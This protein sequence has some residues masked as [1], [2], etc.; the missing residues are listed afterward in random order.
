MAEHQA[1]LTTPLGGTALPA[2][3]RTHRQELARRLDE[4]LLGGNRVDLL[5]DGPDTF[6]A[7]FR[8]I[9]GARDHINIESYIVEADGPGQALAERLIA[10]SRAGVRVNLLFD[11]VGSFGT[12]SGYFAR[13]REAGVAL[14]EYNP[15]PRWRLW[16]GQALHLRDHRKL[17]VVDGRIGFL[18]GV[19]I[20]SVYASGSSP[21][22]LRGN[23]AAE[24]APGWRDL[25]LRVEGPV[26]HSLQRLFMRHWRQ[27]AEL[28]LPMAHYLPPL[29]AAGLQSAALAANEAGRRRN[30]HFSAL[31]GAIAT[32]RERVLLTTAYLAPP[33]RLLRALTQAAQRGVRVELL[34][35]G[36]SDFGM[37]WHAGHSHYTRLLRA[38]VVIHERQGSML[39]SK[40]CVIDGVWCSVGSSNADWRSA[41]HNAEANLIVLDEGFGQRLEQVFHD[42]VACSRQVLLDEWRRRPRW[43]RWKEQFA[44]R[45]EF[46]L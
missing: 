22:H 3:S 10:R 15:I 11:G 42:D 9:D 26:V 5:E 2:T 18:G 46:F 16:L 27:H 14:C 40:A 29:A 7:M 1:T 24:A 44:R 13:L 33:R 38:G 45:F 43:Q 17:L 39:H 25:H 41:I 6:E 37:A 32:A 8:A 21:L 36:T 31:L 12:D 23:A 30:P 34:L 35:P 28:P 20:S 19:N 4:P